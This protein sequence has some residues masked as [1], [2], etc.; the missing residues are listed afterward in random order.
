MAIKLNLNSKEI[1]EMKFPNVPRGYDPLYVD[2]YLDKIIRDYKIIEANHLIENSEIAS[3][4]TK[5]AALE[6]ENE[7]L[8]ID[9]EKYASRL[10]DINENDNVTTSNIDLIKRINVLEKFLY[11]HGYI[12]SQ[13]K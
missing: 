3:L 7:N 5:I 9:N 1:L 12:P 8:K 2:E 4:K 11:Q 13:I 6:K 10:K